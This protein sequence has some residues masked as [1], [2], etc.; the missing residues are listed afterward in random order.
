MNWLLNDSELLYREEGGLLRTLSAAA[1][2]N[3][4]Q[5]NT[6]EKYSGIDKLN[7]RTS[8]SYCS[9]ILCLEQSQHG[10]F[11]I[12]KLYA[13][14]PFNDLF[15]LNDGHSSDHFV[16]GQNWYPLYP[17][18]IEEVHTKLQTHDLSIGKPLTVMQYLV[19]MRDLY[20]MEWFRSN[21]KIAANDLMV[22]QSTSE[23]RSS[24]QFL[25]KLAEYQVKGSNW[26]TFMRDSGVGTVLGDS[27]GL[28]KTVQIIKTICDLIES[29]P[30]SQTLVVCPTA[31][32]ENWAREI[33]RFTRG[34]RYAI[35]VG[36]NRSRDYR[37]FACSLL[38]T[39]YD[40]ARIDKEILSLI[41]WDL[42][43]LDE[44]QFIKNPNSRRTRAIKRIPRKMS[45][46][47]TGT[48]FENHV[49]DIWSIFDFCIPGFLGSKA[50]FSALFTDNKYSADRLG[51]IIA[52]LLLRRTLQDVP[53]DL[54]PL[55]TVPTPISLSLQEAEEYERRKQSYIK[56]NG[57]LG[58]IGHLITDL[59]LP[60]ARIDS[61]SKQKYEYFATV[62]DE[63]IASSEKII[64]FVERKVAIAELA[65][66]YARIPVF[67]LS[68]ETPIRSRQQ[69]V[70]HFSNI[71]GPS[72]MICNPTVGGTGL[73]IT[74]ANHVF[75]FSMQWNPAKFDQ[76]D[77]RAHR[78]GQQKTV[79]AH[80]PYY[81]STI[82]EY[83]WEKT[84]KKRDLASDIVVGNQAQATKRDIEIALSYNPVLH[85]RSCQAY[86]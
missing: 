45:I 8:T 16:H 63:V 62:M 77:A 54:P 55:L 46:A 68:G 80:Y 14:S 13:Q 17:G 52:P 42:V 24:V 6:D 71:N 53:N 35:H 72:M 81:A 56:R 26:L 22:T 21:W 23:H 39:S 66:M 29:E 85:Q 18:S 10:S 36:P 28:G 50:S 2:W 32:V 48:P 73:N 86:G 59:S 37:T 69:A 5:G 76:A 51:R 74:A 1:V 47:V 70:D 25:A 30:S 67:T 40:V 78:R 3:C 58:A 43:I 82:E 27:M 49:T 12:L 31:L 57:A 79:I 7:L 65:R 11:G 4:F 9:P 83:M 61:I 33:E 75:H 34:L 41:N 20:A 19:C 15:P 44:A 38:L 60:P 64:V 84:V